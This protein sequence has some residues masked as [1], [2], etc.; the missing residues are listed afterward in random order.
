[1]STGQFFNN[2]LTNSTNFVPNITLKTD[3]E[4]KEKNYHIDSKKLTIYLY[5][6]SFN[7][8]NI[9]FW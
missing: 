8:H 2:L 6:I 4:E 3:L 5:S 1:M 7:L 9:P